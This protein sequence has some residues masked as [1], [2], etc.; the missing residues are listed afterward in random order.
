MRKVSVVTV[1]YNSKEQTMLTLDALKK[2]D[3]PFIESI[4][5]DGGSDDGTVGVIQNFAK[6]FHGEVRWVSEKDNGIYNA[7]NKGV[8][9]A[10]GDLIGFCWDLYADI[11]TISK[12]VKKVE[13]EQTDGVHGDLVYI[14]KDGRVVRYWKMGQGAIQAG[15]MPAH[16][17]LYLKRSIFE[18]YGLYDES[19]H[20]SGDFEFMV[21]ILKEGN[22]RLSYIPEV[23]VRM[24]YGGVSTSGVRGYWRSIAESYK[25]LRRNRIRFPAG[26][27]L[28]R[29]IRTAGQFFH[30]RVP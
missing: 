8:R 9:M 18:Q 13:D 3:Y 21:C 1:S 26:V 4:I 19:Y 20:C 2:Q 6:E 27:I 12:M 17:T 7:I 11:H 16:P 24:F 5:V 15:W 25:A 10:S 23:L 22:V 29:T 30:R 14:G 28:L